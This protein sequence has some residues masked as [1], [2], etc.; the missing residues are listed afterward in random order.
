MFSIPQSFSAINGLERKEN[1][2]IKTVLNL[3]IN[4]F[5]GIDTTVLQLK[6]TP[7]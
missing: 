6:T 3:L 1:D 4:L 2:E 7:L 5:K